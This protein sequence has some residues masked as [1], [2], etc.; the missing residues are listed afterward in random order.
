MQAHSMQIIYI[1]THSIMIINCV[2]ADSYIN[3]PSPDTTITKQTKY[4]L[5]PLCDPEWNFSF[6]KSHS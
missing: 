1:S 2:F 6:V 5:T 4:V 3:V